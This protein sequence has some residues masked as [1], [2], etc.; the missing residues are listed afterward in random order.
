MVGEGDA[1]DS[2]CYVVIYRTT[3]FYIILLIVFKLMGKREIGQLTLLDLVVSVLMAEIAAM[4]IDNLARPIHEVIL[5]IGLLG[6]L[7]FTSAFITL[8]FKKIRELVDGKPS[9]LIH[10]G[11]I[12]LDEM[13]KQRYTFDD[14][15][16]QLRANNISSIFEVEYAILES[17]G[18]LSSF[19][20]KD[21]SFCPLPII[22]SG[23]IE[24]ENLIKIQKSKEWVEEELEKQGIFSIKEVYY[25]AYDGQQ[26][27]CLTRQS[28]NMKEKK[29]H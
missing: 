5:A 8:R 14:L 17:N 21:I 4:A 3:L 15:M 9:I 7:Q 12:D 22:T 6:F 11:R 19:K 27:R 29:R 1:M 16:L 23:G 20:R 25:A 24:K 28:L 10:Q 13:R 26:L 2:N 18:Q